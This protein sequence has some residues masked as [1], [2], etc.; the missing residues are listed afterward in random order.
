M[1][2]CFVPRDPAA[3]V[4]LLVV[5]REHVRNVNDLRPE[6]RHLV[7]LEHLRAVGER[8]LQLCAGCLGTDAAAPLL[9]FHVPPFNSIEHLHLHCFLPPFDNVF[10]EIK[11]SPRGF[12]CATWAQV[13]A[14]LSAAAGAAGTPAEAVPFSHL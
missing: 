6:E 2:T 8:Q 11:Y 13:H 9:L 14:K 4:H 10:K 7:L 3:R 1:A 12:W 5:P